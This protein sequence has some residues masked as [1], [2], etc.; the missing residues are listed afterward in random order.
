MQSVPSREL[1]RAIT[2]IRYNIPPLRIAATFISTIIITLL[3]YIIGYNA[4]NSSLIVLTQVRSN[5]SSEALAI[6]KR[7]LTISLAKP[8]EKTDAILNKYMFIDGHKCYVKGC[9][10][11]TTLYGAETWAL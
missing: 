9:V 1:L 5:C 6:I 3:Q 10:W 11:S 8:R 2:A 7:L 4:N